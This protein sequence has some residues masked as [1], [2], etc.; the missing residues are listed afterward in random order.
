VA[1]RLAAGKVPAAGFGGGNTGFLV[2]ALQRRKGRQR[3]KL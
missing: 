2:S 1:V 3:R